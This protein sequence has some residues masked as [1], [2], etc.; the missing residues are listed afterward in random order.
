MRTFEKRELELKEAKARRKSD[1]KKFIGCLAAAVVMV[2][3]L[4]VLFGGCKARVQTVYVDKVKTEYKER[5][6]VDS[7]YNRDTVNMWLAG[8]TVFKE[9]TK[10]RER[11][12]LRVDS[13]TRVDS[14]PY[15]VEV[16][17]EVNRLTPWQHRQIVGF[18]I[19]LGVIA[20]AVALKI[21]KV[22]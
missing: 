21:K 12:Q 10:W 9:V 22:V 16:V 8:D 14:I 1:T 15:T 2:S 5:V 19:A 7:V 3:V 6:R 18:W 20:V 4:A 17:K 11:W 13:F